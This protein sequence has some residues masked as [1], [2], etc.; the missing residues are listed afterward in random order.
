MHISAIV[1]E[2]FYLKIKFISRGPTS[3]SNMVPFKY[4]GLLLIRQRV[5]LQGLE[6]TT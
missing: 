6:G 4:G 2:G 5:S 1:R 3:M